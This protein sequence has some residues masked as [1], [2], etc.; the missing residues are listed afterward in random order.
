MYIPKNR[1]KTNLFT[2]GG[3]YMVLATSIEYVGYYHSLY[4]GKFYTGK[5]QNDTNIRELIPITPEAGEDLSSEEELPP[6]LTPDLNK[7]ALFLNDPDP[8]VDEDIW[9]QGDIVRYLEIKRK[10]PLDDDPRELPSQE[11]PQPTEDD[12]KL[13][14]F[15]RYFVKKINE[16]KYIELSKEIYDKMKKKN[17]DYV[18]ELYLC[19][20]LQ[21]TITGPKSQVPI[22]NRN[23]V[24]IAEQR[25]KSLGLGEFLRHD[26]LKFYDSTYKTFTV[27][28]RAIEGAKAPP[29]FHYMP[30]GTLMSDEE[31]K[32]MFGEDY[33]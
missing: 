17:P 10:N 16:L 8:I 22:A 7:I 2:S 27:N 24:L 13:G 29:G 30:D 25:I 15:T 33:N 32:N 11:Y 28:P 6:N 21:W 26:Y 31:H 4:T 5:T 12:Y 9:N 19:F 20:K 23:Q 3:E 1:I 18:W 14:V